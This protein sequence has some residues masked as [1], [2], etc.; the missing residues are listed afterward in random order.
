MNN[1]E[2]AKVE[3]IKTSSVPRHS[4]EMDNFVNLSPWR[5][6][7]RCFFCLMASESFNVNY[8]LIVAFDV[9]KQLR[10]FFYLLL[11]VI[12]SHVNAVDTQH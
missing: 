2:F 5:F 12:E 3:F 10:L 11:A 7:L 4:F 6:C 1:R 9:K 8:L